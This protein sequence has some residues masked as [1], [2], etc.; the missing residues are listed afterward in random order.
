[1]TQDP[2]RNAIDTAYSARQTVDEAV[3]RDTMAQ[4]RQR[5]D[6]AAAAC[7]PQRDLCYDP[8]SGQCLDIYKAPQPGLQPAFVFIHGG[9]WRMLGKGDSA[10]MSETLNR[11]GVAVVAVDYALAPTAALEEIVR[12][13]RAALA[14]LYRHG[15]EHGIDPERL[16]VGGS[17]AGGHLVGALVAGGWRSEMGL[18]EDLV[19]GAMPVSGLFD[20]APIQASFVNAWLNLDE[21]RAHALSPIHHLPARPC[22]LVVAWAEHD[23]TGFHDQSRRYLEAWRGAGFEAQALQVMQRHHFDIVFDWC[24]EASDMTRALLE[25]IRAT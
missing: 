11:A 14:W 8:R 21:A 15:R 24:D 13:V 1:M 3:F 10:F 5:T 18:P 6:A 22:R 23:A 16:F 12:Q 19:K 25:M 7:A 17:S 9:Y 4:Y 20:L 2:N